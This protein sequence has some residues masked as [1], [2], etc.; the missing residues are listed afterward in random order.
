MSACTKEAIDHHTTL[1]VIFLVG[2]C[3]VSIVREQ[4]KAIHK[5]VKR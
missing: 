4:C 1:D 2:I 3:I 5:V